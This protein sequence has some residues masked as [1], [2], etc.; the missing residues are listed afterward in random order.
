MKRRLSLAAF[1]AGALVCVGSATAAP[2]PPSVPAAID[3]LEERLTA[4]EATVASLETELDAVA[5][6]NAA[7]QTTITELTA[8]LAGVTR[9]DANT[10][11][12]AG[13]LQ[14][15]NGS[16]VTDGSPNGLGN[17]LI[18]YNASNGDT[19]GGSH[20]LVVGDN[21]TYLSTSGVVT[22][23]DNRLSGQGAFASG[24][25]NTAQGLYSFVGGGEANRATGDF[26]FA[27]GRG[28]TASGLT[29][30]AAGFINTASGINAFAT[31]RQNV[32]SNTAAFVSG[33]QNVASG[34]AA[35]VGGGGAQLAQSGSVFDPP[36]LPGST[37]SGNYSFIG[38][39]NNKTAGPGS[40][41]NIFGT[42]FGTC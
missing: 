23:N 20:N 13:N 19:K 17:L 39:G 5:A 14:L 4:L 9:P 37:A 41:A 34:F 16:G 27:S 2:A 35:F 31:G 42:I 33:W 24:H 7:Q 32:A 29:S 18:G 40:C 3:Q 12:F 21:H 38:G 26:A 6:Q 28:S 10:I 36:L 22:G 11:R 30:F 1:A 15:V 25:S 8:L